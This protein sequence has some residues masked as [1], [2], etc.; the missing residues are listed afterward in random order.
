MNFWRDTF[1][2]F[3]CYVGVIVAAMPFAIFYAV[4]T[5]FHGKSEIVSVSSLV[6][7]LVC[8]HFGWKWVEKRLS[9]G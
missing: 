9:H 2:L 7:A 8:G 1:R 6:A 3:C 5:L 4:W